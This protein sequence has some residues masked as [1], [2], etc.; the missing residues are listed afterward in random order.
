[1]EGLRR[2]LEGAAS[3]R[4]LAESAAAIVQGALLQ[5]RLAVG[6]EDIGCFYEEAGCRCM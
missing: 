1:M 5:V 2:E 3:A 4:R 6:V